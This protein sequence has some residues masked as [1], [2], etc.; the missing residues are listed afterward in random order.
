[1]NF[2]EKNVYSHPNTLDVDI[3]VEDVIYQD[4]TV[5]TLH[6]SYVSKRSGGL[7]NSGKDII[8][9]HNKLEWEKV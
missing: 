3:Y 2:Q 5:A 1:M 9:V 7:L 6:V 8:K 4:D